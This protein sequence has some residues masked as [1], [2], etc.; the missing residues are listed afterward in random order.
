VTELL[1][2]GFF[3]TA[4][5]AATLTGIAC[6]VT[7]VWIFLLR[8]A[9]LGICIS[10]AAFA[11]ALL[12]LLIGQ[13][14]FPFAFLFSVLAAAA[15][16]PLSDRG[17]LSPDTSLGILFSA[18]LGLAFLFMAL[19]PGSRS[20]ALNLLWG[21]VLTLDSADMT[22]LAVAASVVLL[23]TI[24]FFKEIQAV[25]FSRELAA[26]SGVRATAIFYG[27]LILCGLVIA[28]CLK[29]AGGLLVFS[30]VLNPA[31]AARQ[32]TSRM[33]TLY[34]L[35]A[36]FGVVSGVGGLCI[37]GFFAVPAGAS[38]VL[39][40]SAIFFICMAVSPKGRDHGREAENVFQ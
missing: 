18:M 12:A 14:V 17:S 26:A 30:L 11:G 23:A 15:L 32:L 31:A 21:N 7:G 34:L 5:C 28:A 24:L 19:L 10:H 35:A 2:F 9:F 27:L 29:A 25:V 6:S 4:L 36:L 20:A 40:S 3:Q 22:V 38:A 16:G 33:K 37:S 8:L 1:G 39:C 13:P